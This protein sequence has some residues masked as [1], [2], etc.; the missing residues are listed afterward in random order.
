M[1]M[2]RMHVA[3]VRNT[4]SYWKVRNGIFPGEFS[5][6]LIQVQSQME[7]AKERTARERER[8]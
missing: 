1:H 2:F 5:I 4:V 6:F 7:R 8:E 3:R